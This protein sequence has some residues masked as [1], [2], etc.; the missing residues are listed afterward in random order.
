MKIEQKG[1]DAGRESRYGVLHCGGLRPAG[2]Q[3]E[4]AKRTELSELGGETSLAVEVL[5]IIRCSIFGKVRNGTDL[6]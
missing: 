2:S 1:S 4:S 5:E 6:G 3:R